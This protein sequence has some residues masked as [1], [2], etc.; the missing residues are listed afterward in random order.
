MG[1]IKAKDYESEIEYYFKSLKDYKKLTQEEEQE[2][3]RRI[4]NGDHEAANILVEHNLKFVVNVAKG[5]RDSGLPFA[6]LISEGNLG[7]I[8]AANKYNPD[9]NTKF[10]S[11]AIWWIK[12]YIQDFI[13]SQNTAN[14]ISTD[15]YLDYQYREDQINEE[16]EDNLNNLK[17]RES[18]IADLLVCLKDRELK[19][20]QMSFGLNGE[21]EMTLNEIS[22]ATELSMERVRQIKDNALMKLK[23]EALSKSN[24][25]FN[26][27]KKLY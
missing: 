16:F 23:C 4:I 12:C 20:I 21:K 19:V 11:Y 2:L 5:Y 9:K 7:L 18:S 22:K 25:Y 27:M 10:I 8:H 15:N 26:D 6:D 14:E 13:E 1:K 24:N 3:G 17:D